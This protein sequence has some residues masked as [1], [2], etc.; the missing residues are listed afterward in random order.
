MPLQ[1]IFYEV[2]NID[3]AWLELGSFLCIKLMEVL[4]QYELYERSLVLS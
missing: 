2:S 1:C 4:Q 3:E